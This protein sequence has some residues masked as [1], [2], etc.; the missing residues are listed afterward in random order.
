MKA[1][2]PSATVHLQL[3]K[4]L[5]ERGQTGV[6]TTAFPSLLL[7]EHIKF[8]Q[9]AGPLGRYVDPTRGSHKIFSPI[10]FLSLSSYYYPCSVPSFLS[11]I[12]L[13]TVMEQELPESTAPFLAVCFFIST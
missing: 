5:R 8:L 7:S 1:L 2:A 3:K 6:I 11:Y 4:R 12:T 9:A 13:E 10:A